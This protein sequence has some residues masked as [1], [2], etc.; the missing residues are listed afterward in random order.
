MYVMVSLSF[1]LLCYVAGLYGIEQGTN[2]KR[3]VVAG[4]AGYPAACRLKESAW[5]DESAKMMRA[6]EEL[7]ADGKVRFILQTGDMMYFT[8]TNVPISEKF[9]GQAFV[10]NA[11]DVAFCRVFGR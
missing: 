3:N 10:V 7:S 8:L 6:F 2:M 4:K 11:S 9:H 1:L 5:G